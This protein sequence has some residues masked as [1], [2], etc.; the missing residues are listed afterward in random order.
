MLE[1][2]IEQLSVS[3]ERCRKL[4]HISKIAV[5]VGAVWIVITLF[6]LV[7]F[8][9]EFTFGALAAIIAGLVLLGSNKTTWDQTEQALRE[10]EAKRNALIG[11]LS[12]RLVDDPASSPFE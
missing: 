11:R 1:E 9:P 12:L 3:R 6:G 5:A 4:S 8:S 2:R 10:A 7:S